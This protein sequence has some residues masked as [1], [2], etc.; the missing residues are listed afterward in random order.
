MKSRLVELRRVSRAVAK[1]AAPGERSRR[2]ITAAGVEAGQTTDRHG[3]GHRYGEAVARL[4]ADFESPLG[5]LDAEVA[6]DQPEDDRFAAVEPGRARLQPFPVGQHE[7]E[8]GADHRAAE[9]AQRNAESLAAVQAQRRLPAAA[10][11]NA[12]GHGGEHDGGIGPGHEQ[13]PRPIIMASGRRRITK[14]RKSENTKREELLSLV[15][16]FALSLFRVF[17][18]TNSISITSQAPFAAR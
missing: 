11:R 5:R 10:E 12:R 1:V 14:T 15:S 18:I 9:G 16:L 8:F 4:D 13:G 2:T 7:R 3:R 6:A 17:V